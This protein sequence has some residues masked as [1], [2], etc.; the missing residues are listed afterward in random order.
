M[1]GTRSSRNSRWRYDQII[2]RVRA[3]LRVG[4]V[5]RIG[6]EKARQT[7]VCIPRQTPNER[8]VINCEFV[9]SHPIRVRIVRVGIAVARSERD[10]RGELEVLYVCS[11][12]DSD[13]K[14][15]TRSTYAPRHLRRK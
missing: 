10:L 7:P 2:V 9:L 8:L 11:K 14:R 4:A 13:R 6:D 1:S 12:A 5:E 15:Q 3:T